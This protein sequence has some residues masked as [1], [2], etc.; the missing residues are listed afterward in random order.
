MWAFHLS[1]K[2]VINAVSFVFNGAEYRLNTEQTSGIDEYE[3]GIP[4]TSVLFYE[5]V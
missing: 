4:L 3:V 1:D 5:R 2:T